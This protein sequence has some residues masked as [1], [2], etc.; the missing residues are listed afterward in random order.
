MDTMT[1]KFFNK[2][3]NIL[4]HD[5]DEEFYMIETDNLTELLNAW[6]EQ[7]PTMPRNDATVYFASY[8]GQPIPI[9]THD[10]FYDVLNTISFFD[11]MKMRED[12]YRKQFE[13]KK[14]K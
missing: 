6:N 9:G 3:I 2:K 4:T 12:M 7:S 11:H 14:N 10:T 13:E 5:L 1:T 8:D